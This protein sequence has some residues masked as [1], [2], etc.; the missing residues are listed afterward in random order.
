LRVRAVASGG[1]QAEG[2]AWAEGAPEPDSWL[3]HKDASDPPAGKAAVWGSPISGTP[4]RFDDLKVLTVE[5]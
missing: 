2:R 3:V 4:I 5:N 1:W